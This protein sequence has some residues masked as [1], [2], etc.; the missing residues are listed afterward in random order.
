MDKRVLVISH[1]CFNKTNNM[2]ITL[3]SYFCRWDKEKIA[4]IF[5]V[6]DIPDSDCCSKFYKL[7]DKNIFDTIFGKKSYGYEVKNLSS[8]QNSAQLSF[9]TKIA[10]NRTPFIYCIRNLLWRMGKWNNEKLWRFIDDFNPEVI[11]YASGDYVFSYK[12]ALFIAKKKRIPLIIGCFDDFYISR[13]FSFNPFYYL[14]RLLFKR[15]TKKTFFYCS[16]FTSS[17]ELM[18]KDYSA[19]FNKKGFT[20]YKSSCYEKAESYNLHGD[21]VYAGNLGYGRATQLVNLGRFLKKKGL[22]LLHVY[23][24]EVRVG[25]TKLMS[26]NNGIVFHGRVSGNEIEMIIKKA[27][28]IVHVESFKKN[29]IKRVKYSLSTKIADYLKSGIPIIAVGA[30]DVASI[31]YLYKN[32]AAFC[33]LNEDSLK[34]I[35]NIFNK[36]KINKVVGNAQE[37][38]KLN[39]TE[40]DN[41]QK[42]KVLINLSV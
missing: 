26:E 15:Q 28:F 14:N 29:N 4:Q 10:R 3:N 5:F 32:N 11:Y 18:L 38:Y 41:S 31:N 24:G 25:L 19:I 21:I 2:G 13:K 7:T 22:P 35:D 17:S 8:I 23:S 12:I 20:I 39:H 40:S 34:E 16:G 42:M 6:N 36:D 1:N 33:F 30:N 27:S 37:L 9:A